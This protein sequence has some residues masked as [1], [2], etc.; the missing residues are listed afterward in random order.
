MGNTTHSVGGVYPDGCPIRS[1]TLKIRP[2]IASRFMGDRPTR[3]EF[4]PFD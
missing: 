1:I 2:L 3:L 4:I